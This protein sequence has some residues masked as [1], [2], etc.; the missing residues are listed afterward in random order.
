MLRSIIN[1]S[2]LTFGSPHCMQHVAPN[3]QQ[4][5]GISARALAMVSIPLDQLDPSVGMLPLRV[6]AAFFYREFSM[7]HTCFDVVVATFV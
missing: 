3:A 2:V 4:C 6:V 7:F 5:H 1:M